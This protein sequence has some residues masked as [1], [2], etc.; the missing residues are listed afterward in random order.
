[1]GDHTGKCA[2]LVLQLEG[3]APGGDPQYTQEN[4]QQKGCCQEYHTTLILESHKSKCLQQQLKFCFQ[5]T[6][7]I[8][9]VSLPNKKKRH[10][11]DRVLEGM[12]RTRSSQGRDREE[13]EALT[14]RGWKLSGESVQQDQASLRFSSWVPICCA[15]K[16]ES[17]CDGLKPSQLFCS[18]TRQ[19]ADR[20]GAWHGG[21]RVKYFEQ[22]RERMNQLSFIPSDKQKRAPRTPTHFVQGTLVSF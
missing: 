17:N 4:L 8:K 18:A 7:V 1:M 19:T 5:H 6:T 20:D 10:A 22:K 15:S 2:A 12:V 14:S 11:L 16:G 9:A 3:T 13:N 21:F